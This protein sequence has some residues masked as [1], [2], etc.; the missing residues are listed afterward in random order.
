MCHVFACLEQR[1]DEL[2][3][4]NMLLFAVEDGWSLVNLPQAIGFEDNEVLSKIPPNEDK[5]ATQKQTLK[6]SKHPSLF[7]ELCSS[8][9][10]RRKFYRK[11]L[12]AA[13]NKPD[14]QF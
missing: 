8:M 6:P 5:T 11:L 4:S 12:G 3:S 9:G 13:L 10:L 7:R 14:F 1:L 2:H